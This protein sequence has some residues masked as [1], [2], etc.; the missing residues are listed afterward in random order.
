[1]PLS[2]LELMRRTREGGRGVTRRD[3]LDFVVDG[4]SLQDW[5]PRSEVT[6]LGWSRVERTDIGRLLLHEAP[7]LPT[8]RV[9]LYICP[10][11]G[12]IECGAVTARITE[13]TD[14][15]VW[16]DFAWEGQ[17]DYGAELDEDPLVQLYEGVGP[18]EFQKAAY[19]S[20]LN[21]RLTQLKI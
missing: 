4:R 11:C 17:V 6:A 2:T 1:M 19:Q 18:F 12:D 21:E 14:S 5:F 20:I 3:Y 15:F 10:E 13:T 9:A 8:G 7:E 16:S